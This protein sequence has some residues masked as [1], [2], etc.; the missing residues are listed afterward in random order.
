MGTDV[1]SSS[2]P[3]ASMQNLL[4][5]AAEFEPGLVLERVQPAQADARDAL[6]LA[7]GTGTAH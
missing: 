2:R 7:P 5:T 6:F 4:D 1:V 3:K